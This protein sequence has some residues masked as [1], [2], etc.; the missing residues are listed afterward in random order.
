MID[1]LIDQYYSTLEELQASE[2]K[3]GRYLNNLQSHFGTNLKVEASINIDEQEDIYGLLSLSNMMKSTVTGAITRLK[4]IGAR[5]TKLRTQYEK[6]YSKL[7]EDSVIAYK[8]LHVISSCK[9][10][11]LLKEVSG[12]VYT[13]VKKEIAEST[14]NVCV[15]V[16]DQNN[17]I[18][19][20]TIKNSNVN[21]SLSMTI[22]NE[23]KG[24]DIITEFEKIHDEKDT[25]VRKMK[26][27]TVENIVIASDGRIDII[28]VDKEKLK[29]YNPVI[30]E[31]YVILNVSDDDSMNFDEAGRSLSV[32]PEVY[33]KMID[34][35]VNATGTT[36]DKLRYF[37][38]L[39]EKSA[40][41]YFK[42]S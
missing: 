35:I 24:S 30:N 10:P 29:D 22:D 21:I 18:Y 34:D 5:T 11:K 42:I 26:S 19:S 38:K 37:T 8:L 2:A 13:S 6:L 25:T 39:D 36:K 23:G 3:F 27:S 41:V 14:K 1:K 16:D 7:S 4:Q 17:I 32:K 9:L 33:V 20:C 15:N 40:E 28:S 12:V 31:N